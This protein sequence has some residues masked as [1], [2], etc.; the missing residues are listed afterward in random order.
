MQYHKQD[1][2]T[3]TEIYCPIVSS[4]AGLRRERV[5]LDDMGHGHKLEQQRREEFMNT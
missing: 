3:Y 1:T 2:N 4:A 5:M